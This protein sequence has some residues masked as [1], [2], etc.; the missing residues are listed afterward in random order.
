MVE[1]A[2]FEVIDLGINVDREKIVEAV[3]ENR[4][5]ILGLSALLTT[6]MPEIGAVIDALA[7]AGLREQVKVLVG[8]APVT[9]AF[10]RDV[11]ADG[12]GRDAATAVDLCRDILKQKPSN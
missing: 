8:G 10:A 5:D 6:T 9:E 11:G 3:R 2:D 12:Y 4:P 7:R 1:G